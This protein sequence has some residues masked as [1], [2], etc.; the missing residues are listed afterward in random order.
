M[1]L[2]KTKS[3]IIGLYFGQDETIRQI[4][5]VVKKSSRDANKVVKEPNQKL[6]LSQPLRQLDSSKHMN[7][8][9]LI[10]SYFLVICIVLS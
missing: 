1:A 3:E 2:E 7:M 4:V 10:T 6:Q 8:N 5:K 9:L